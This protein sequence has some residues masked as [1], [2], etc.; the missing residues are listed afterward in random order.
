MVDALWGGVG[1]GLNNWMQ[2]L[3]G[4][5]SSPES[6]SNVIFRRCPAQREIDELKARVTRRE[7]LI[8]SLEDENKRLRKDIWSETDSAYRARDE[9]KKVEMANDVLVS[10]GTMECNMSRPPIRAARARCPWERGGSTRCP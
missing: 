9:L 10:R 1:C 8:D 2:V 5:G 4:A 3:M 6:C 7:R